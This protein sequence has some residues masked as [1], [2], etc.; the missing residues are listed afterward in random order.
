MV[1]RTV[2]VPQLQFI[3]GRRHSFRSEEADP[4][5]PVCSADHGDLQLLLI[6]GGRCPC[7]AG[8]YRFSGAAVEKTLA[9]PQLQLVEKSVTFYVPSHSAVTRSVFAFG[10]QDFG[11]FWVMTFGNVPVFSAYWFNTGCM[12][13]SVYRDFWKFSLVLDPRISAECLVRLRILAHATD[14]GG[15]YGSHCRKLWSLRSCSP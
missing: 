7:C 14:H 11:L 9:L 6:F 10:V 5:G 1:Q 12:S 15:Y 8:S 2:V 13:A 4:H 3:V